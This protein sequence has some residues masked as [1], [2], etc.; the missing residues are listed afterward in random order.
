MLKIG[1]HDNNTWNLGHFNAW[2]V[3]RHTA[4]DGLDST[5][6]DAFTDRKRNKSKLGRWG[7]IEI[8]HKMAPPGAAE[9]ADRV[10]QLGAGRPRPNER[11]RERRPK[12]SR[13]RRT[14]TKQARPFFV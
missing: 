14:T 11:E 5:G 4:L 6:P 10:H 13:S 9:G 2:G 7:K 8:G 12:A 3:R 1:I